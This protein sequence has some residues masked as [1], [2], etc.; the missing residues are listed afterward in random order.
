MPPPIA[1]TCGPR[2]RVRR[3][4]MR[5]SKSSWR[6]IGTTALTIER[7]S[8]QAPMSVAALAAPMKIMPR[9]QRGRNCS[10]TS[11]TQAG[12]V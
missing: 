6:S 5:S 9:T 11:P 12:K 7:L 1:T 10:V 8:F 3:S 2:P 4:Q